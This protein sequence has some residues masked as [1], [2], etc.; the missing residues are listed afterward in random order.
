MIVLLWVGCLPLFLSV[1]SVLKQERMWSSVQQAWGSVF[2]LACVLWLLM[3]FSLCSVFRPPMGDDDND[4]NSLSEH[5]LR[6]SRSQF[7]VLFVYFLIF[8]F[9]TTQ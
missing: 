1:G 7:Q 4:K 9:D 5:L 6:G 8:R 3:Y 2:P